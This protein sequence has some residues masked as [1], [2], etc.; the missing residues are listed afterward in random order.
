MKFAVLGFGKI[1]KAILKD[2]STYSG[3]ANIA[4]YDPQGVF[5]SDHK[6]NVSFF[7]QDPLDQKNSKEVFK[8]DTVV[9][10][11]LPARFRP[12]LFKLAEENNSR[13]V[14]IT[15]G[16]DVL[17]PEKLRSGGNFLIVPDAGLAPG[18]TNLIVGRFTNDLDIVE[19]VK[20]YVGGLPDK[21]IPPLEYK[22]VFAIES[23]VDEYVN[24]CTVIESGKMTK[25]EALSGLED[26]E[27]GGR[28]YEAFYTDGLRTLVHTI[29]P[30]SNMFE[31]TVRYRGHCEKVK[32]LRELGY[33]SSETLKVAGVEV[34]PREVSEKLLDSELKNNDIGDLV[35]FRVTVTGMK[36]GMM[37]TFSAEMS[38][39]STATDALTS[40]GRTTAFPASII[41]QLI[42]RGKIRKSGYAP[43]ETIGENKEIFDLILSELKKRKIFIML[44]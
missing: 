28:K 23:V 32:L 33:F 11:A 14:D 35:L 36:E 30:V 7:R 31:K 8:S 4:V 40:M 29:K 39:H 26:I 1:G 13:L 22:V 24:P 19:N 25:V 17:S 34:S 43:L 16:N 42:A 27:F 18:L 3:N 38:D 12:K 15:F 10:S 9:V 5:P 20:I 2:L 44:G 41:A 21:P 6:E 37:K